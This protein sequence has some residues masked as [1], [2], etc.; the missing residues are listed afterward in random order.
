MG[1]HS[2]LQTDDMASCCN[3]RS[4]RAA[5]SNSKESFKWLEELRQ[6]QPQSYS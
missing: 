6:L 5:P 2:C 1:V 3:C 4:I